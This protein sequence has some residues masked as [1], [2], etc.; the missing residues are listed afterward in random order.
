MNV[1]LVSDSSSNV[2][3]LAGAAYESVPLKIIFGDK[4][5]VDVPGV[6]LKQMYADLKA[7]KGTSGTSCPN[8]YEWLESFGEAANVFAITITGTLSGSFSACKQAAEEYMA[9]HQ[10][11]KVCVLDSLSAGPELRLVLER[12]RDMAQQGEKTFEQM[13]TAIREYM[14]H[15]HLLFM[16][17]S[18]TNLARNGRCSPAVAK[19][20]GVLGICVVGKASDE[21]TLQPL[22]KCRGE[23]K[24]LET[25]LKE[26][27]EGGF[28][29]GRVRISHGLNQKAA[30]Q[31]KEMVLSAFPGS[32]VA[33]E[34]STALC[35]YYAEEG[36]IMVGYEDAL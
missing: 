22:H 20:A 18:M 34:Q 31:L 25:I 5:V 10:G 36:G 14:K 1:K 3:S 4:E 7:H 11:A 32:D 13:E 26:M 29:G 28:K 9:A 2:L 30:Q 6:N 8:V 23:Q 16:L 33:I 35:G 24:S 17:K 15:T 12:L 19:I 27:K 21:G